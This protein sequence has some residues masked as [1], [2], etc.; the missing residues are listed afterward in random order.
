M[1][2][3]SQPFI[4]SPMFSSDLKYAVDPTSLNI[5]TT[6]ILSCRLI[7][8]FALDWTQVIVCSQIWIIFNLV[9]FN[10]IQV[11]NYTLIVL[12]QSVRTCILHEAQ[13]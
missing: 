4:M 3:F 1:F 8:D 7:C 6:S 10:K 11:Q 2:W 9:L 12:H 13:D 5:I